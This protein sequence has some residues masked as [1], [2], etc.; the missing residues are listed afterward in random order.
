[1]FFCI[2]RRDFLSILQL[3]SAIEAGSTVSIFRRPNSPQMSETTEIPAG[4]RRRQTAFN[5]KIDRHVRGRIEPYGAF[6]HN[7]H[8]SASRRVQ[9]LGDCVRQ[10]ARTPRNR[11]SPQSP[12]Q[13]RTG[14]NRGPILKKRIRKATDRAVSFGKR[15]NRAPEGNRK[16]PRPRRKQ[17]Q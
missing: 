12:P 3:L 5:G 7:F 14:A 15:R 16:R 13:I 17:A 11:G 6:A 1:M 10:E 4:Y 2:L 9:P 8:N